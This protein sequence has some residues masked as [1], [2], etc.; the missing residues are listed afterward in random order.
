MSGADRRGAL[1]LALAGAAAAWPVLATAQAPKPVPPPSGRRAPGTPPTRLALV[2]GAGAA[3]GLAHIGVLKSLAQAGIKPDLV[4]GCS[5]GALVGAFYA[6][7]VT[8]WQIEEVALRAKESELADYIA[9]GK[10]GMLNGDALWRF[11]DDGLRGARIERLRT[12]FATVATD[13]RNGEPV[14]FDEGPVADAVRASCSMPGVFVPMEWNGR[15]LVDGG[16]VSPVPVKLARRLGADVVIAV[17]VGVRP[18]RKVLPGLYEV[19]LQSFE[20]MG[21]ALADHESALADHALHPDTARWTSSD[22]SARREMIQAGYEAAQEA[23]PALRR[24]V[25]GAA[26]PRR[27]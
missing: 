10:R 8:P 16:L 9:T 12:R 18:D 3:R 14:V 15:E 17:D 22:F 7:G 26:R 25:D 4:V 5:A 6:A 2:L 20:V 11:V 19:L 21:R 13:L 23:L 27:S 24:L 1:R